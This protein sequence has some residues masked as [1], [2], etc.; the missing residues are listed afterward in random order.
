MRRV[1]YVFIA[2]L[3]LAFVVW[4]CLS[5]VVGSMCGN[6]L[7]SEY[8][9]PDGKNKV[10]VFVR[11]CGATTGFWTNVSITN[12]GHKLREDETS[13]AVTVDDHETGP[14]SNR[15]GGGEVLAKWISNDTVVF[16]INEAA[17]LLK[18]EAEVRGVTIIYE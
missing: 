5:Q 9:S 4:T 3:L 13:N 6:Q 10:I 8:L 7:V 15:L 12:K 16:R 11:D 17:K 2:I 18:K 1:Y 14:D